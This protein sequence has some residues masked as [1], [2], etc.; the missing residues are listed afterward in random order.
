[1]VVAVGAEAGLATCPGGGEVRSQT[2][3]EKGAARIC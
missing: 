1:M 2:N 3:F